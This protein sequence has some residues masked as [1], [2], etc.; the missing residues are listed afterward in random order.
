MIRIEVTDELKVKSGIAR[1]TGKPYE[2]V[3]QVGFAHL[4]GEN[5]QAQKYPTQVSIPVRKGS[6]PLAAGDYTLAPESIV[7]GQWGALDLRMVLRPIQSRQVPK[8]A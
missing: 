2:I 7:L 6:Q 1:G 3:E 5:G 4:V 8:A